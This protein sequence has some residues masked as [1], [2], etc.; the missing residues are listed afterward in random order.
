M[1]PRHI[2][3]AYRPQDDSIA[4]LIDGACENLSPQAAEDLA[5]A[6]IVALDI[7]QQEHRVQREAR[8]AVIRRPRGPAANDMATGGVA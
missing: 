2:G 7:R 5:R 4:L 8:L 1:P 3:A 6:L